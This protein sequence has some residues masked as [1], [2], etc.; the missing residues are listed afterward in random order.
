ML[1]ILFLIYNINGLNYTTILKNNSINTKSYG[2]SIDKVCYVKK[3]NNSFYS[4]IKNVFTNKSSKRIKID[5][6]I[7][8]EIQQYFEYLK[9]RLIYLIILSIHIFFIKILFSLII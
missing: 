1:I 6:N 8:L 3:E 7:N 5:A 4:V 9:T 2:Y